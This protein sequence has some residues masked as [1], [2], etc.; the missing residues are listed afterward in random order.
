MAEP[1]SMDLRFRVL[2]AIGEGYSGRG[3][4]LRFGV[5]AASVSRWRTR[6]REQGDAAPKPM[7]GDRR[8]AGTEAHAA[9]ILARVEA[10]PDL[11]LEELRAALAAEG[12]TVSY[13]AL[14]RLLRRHKITRKKS[15][16]TLRSKS[17][18]TS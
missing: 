10:T 7:G 15:P 18:R 14:W 6:A 5:S 16:R 9:T 11:T 13:G 12:V 1:L 17:A 4:G 2:A 8:S 3:A